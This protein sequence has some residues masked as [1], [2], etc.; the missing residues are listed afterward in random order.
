MRLVHE[1]LTGLKRRMHQ[2]DRKVGLREV[3]ADREARS[4]VA[5]VQCLS[6]ASRPAFL[7]GVKPL[8]FQPVL[9]KSCSRPYQ[10]TRFASSR[11]VA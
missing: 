10:T 9:T 1:L 2:L 8:R 7:Y 6:H 11:L 3:A 4:S 5:S